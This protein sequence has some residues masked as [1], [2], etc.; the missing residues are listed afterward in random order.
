[1]IRQINKWIFRHTGT[2]YSL[3]RAAIFI[4]A[5]SE[6]ST[7]KTLFFMVL[8]YMHLHTGVDG[9]WCAPRSSKPVRGARNL[10]GG[11]DSHIFPPRTSC[12]CRMSFFFAEKLGRIDKA[13]DLFPRLSIKK[14][15]YWEMEK[16]SLLC[17]QMCAI[18]STTIWWGVGVNT[19]WRR[20]ASH[21]YVTE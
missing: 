12:V 4:F 5:K 9:C 16:F 14:W 21:M 2:F 19:Q 13:R 3:C 7:W 1:M 6:K 10:P 17:V 8:F 15:Y 11:F 18:M 20:T